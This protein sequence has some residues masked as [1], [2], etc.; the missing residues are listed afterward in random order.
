MSVKKIV[1][2]A[3]AVLILVGIVYARATSRF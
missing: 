2:I 1:L 3:A